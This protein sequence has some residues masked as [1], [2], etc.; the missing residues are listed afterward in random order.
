MQ[1]GELGRAVSGMGK[2]CTF[3][4]VHLY[5]QERKKDRKKE[6]KSYYE[7]GRDEMERATE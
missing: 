7:R 2:Y 4:I 6:R 3:T 1:G 5:F